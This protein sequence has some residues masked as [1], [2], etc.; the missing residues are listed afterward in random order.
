MHSEHL[1][2][3]WI[4]PPRQDRSRDTHERIV[5][6]TR[7][8]MAQ[9]RAF[10][11]IGVAELAKHAHSSVGAFYSRFRDKDA[12]LRVLQEELY[13]EGLATAEDTFRI[14]SSMVVPLEA[15]VRAFV[16]LAVGS[17]REQR[18][19]RRALLL[20]MARDRDLRERATELS[21]ATCAGLVEVLARR[22]PDAAIARVEIAVDVAHRM[23]YGMLDQW[24]L[25][26]YGTPTGR[27]LDDRELTEELAASVHAY[28]KVTL[29]TTLPRN[30]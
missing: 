11:E 21:K 9:G 18:D 1:E 2:L 5:E 8:L 7:D 10:H 28:L 6:A 25:F 13:R 24:L 15:L 20:E 16:G 14:A 12:L 23:V 29:E 19:L 30:S 17:Y 26:A 27:D 4:K 22:Y 3:R